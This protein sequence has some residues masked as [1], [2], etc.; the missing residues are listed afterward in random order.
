MLSMNSARFIFLALIAC[1]FSCSPKGSEVK[2]PNQ[3]AAILSKAGE[4]FLFPDSLTYIE[5]GVTLRTATELFL[6]KKRYTIVSIIWGDCHVCMGKFK[7][8]GSLLS[9]DH[10]DNTQV[11][12]VVSTA[13][14][15]HFMR[16]YFPMISYAGSIVVDTNETFTSLNKLSA[17]TIEYNIFLLDSS[18]SIKIVGD[19]LV[20]PELLSLYLEVVNEK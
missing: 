5:N 10:F 20:F 12:L 17:S 16:I 1:M 18:Y 4:T 8:W 9:E 2:F 13:S 14:I 7:K 6:L 3:E 11:I 15:E 19:P